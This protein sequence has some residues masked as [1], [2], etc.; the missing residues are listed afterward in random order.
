MYGLL[1]VDYFSY[2]PFATGYH[3][4]NVSTSAIRATDA[5]DEAQNGIALELLCYS[6]PE[7]M[8]MLFCTT[9]LHTSR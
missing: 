9:T 1:L 8:G 7:C 2:S 4:D 3:N 6:G 5:T